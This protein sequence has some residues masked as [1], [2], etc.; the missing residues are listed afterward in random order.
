MNYIDDHNLNHYTI[1]PETNAPF[2][3][4][5]SGYANAPFVYLFNQFDKLTNTQFDRLNPT[6]SFSFIGY[7]V[8]TLFYCLVAFY[9]LKKIINHN[10]YKNYEI[11]YLIIFL[12][13]L[14]HFI[15]GRF[16]MAH[17]F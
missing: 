2:H 17:S 12:S 7:F 13:T 16:L 14:V 11:L 8:G 6:G 9:L 3:P 5:G 15:S 1:H 4:P 10:K